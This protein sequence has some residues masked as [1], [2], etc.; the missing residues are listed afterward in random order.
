MC[1]NNHDYQLG[2]KAGIAQTLQRVSKWLDEDTINS[3]QEE[4]LQ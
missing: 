4:L 1:G 2:Y 3:L